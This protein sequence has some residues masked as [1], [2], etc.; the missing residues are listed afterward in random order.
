MR[1][2]NTG[3]GDL[4]MLGG[5]NAVSSCNGPCPC[6]FCTCPK[7]RLSAI[8][9]RYQTRTRRDIALLAHACEGTCPGCDML[10]VKEVTNKK[11]QVPLLTSTGVHPPVP[12]GK[13]GKGVTPLNLHFGIVAGQTCNFDME[14]DDW[15][16][17]IMHA[18]L[19]IEGGILQKGLLAHIGVLVDPGAPKSHG[20]ALYDE[21]KA[22]GLTM[23]KTKLAKKS[24][25]L[26]QYDLSFKSSSFTG[27]GGEIIHRIRNPLIKI[28]MPDFECGPWVED[29]ILFG[30]DVAARDAAVKES[31]R[32]AKNGTA[33][34][35]RFALRIVWQAWG[36]C[37][38]LLNKDMDDTDTPDYEQVWA[39][40]AE[41]TRLAMEDFVRK[42]VACMGI[43]EGLY[44]HILHAHAHTQIKKWGSLKLRQSQGLEHCHKIRK[45]IGCEATNRKPGERLGTM[46]S[47]V[48]VSAYVD[49]LA[50]QSGNSMPLCTSRRR[51]P[52]TKGSWLRLPESKPALPPFLPADK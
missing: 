29:A 41:E 40:R 35:Q 5:Q 2:V 21:M 23:K 9:E 50:S 43:T 42:H 8:G 45:R 37:W 47:H 17:C 27:R 52:S 6:P 48:Q 16:I 13:K 44:L 15:S 30:P 24:K 20:E 22:N 14:P 51:N 12:A 49:R 3:A 11:T 33:A 1:I 32:A 39:A 36:E 46:L 28:V 18:N 26:D 31:T 25:K 38:A 4:A 10:I 19:C 7:N 34:K